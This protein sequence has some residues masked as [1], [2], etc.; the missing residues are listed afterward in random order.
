MRRFLSAA[1]SLPRPLWLL[2]GV[3]GYTAYL[4]N[5]RGP[6]RPT[7]LPDG[8]GPITHRFYRA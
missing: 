5:P 3:L 2:A 6:L 4:Q 8:V 1:R 7:D